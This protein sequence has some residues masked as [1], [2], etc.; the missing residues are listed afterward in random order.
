[1]KFHP[2]DFSLKVKV[3]S[4]GLWFPERPGHSPEPR[5]LPRDCATSSQYSESP[6][7]VESPGDTQSTAPDL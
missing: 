2:Q 6:Y 7:F 5:S 1:M 4:T 3:N